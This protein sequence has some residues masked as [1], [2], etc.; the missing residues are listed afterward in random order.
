MK[1][2]IGTRKSRLALAQ[3]EMVVRALKSR[4]PDI[5]TEIVE[6]SSQG[7]RI[8]DRPI[9]EISGKGV[10]SSELEERILSGDI[11][12]A[13]HSAKDLDIDLPRG[14][15]ISAVLKRGDHRDVL[16]L[17]K[18]AEYAPTDKLL[19]G[20]GSIRRRENI[21]RFF[22]NAVFKDIRGNVETRLNK[23]RSGEYNGIILA[24]AGLERL[25][26]LCKANGNI[27]IEYSELSFKVFE[28]EEFV[29]AA[30]QGIISAEA[31][32]NSAAAEI[33]RDISDR[34]AY[35]SFETEREFLRICG[36]DCHTPAGIFTEVS[37]G[38]IRIICSADGREILAAEGNVSDKY[39]LLKGLTAKK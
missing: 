30:C 20:T 27:G 33:F 7:D 24:A 32:K 37:G 26:I 11:D 1:I 6:I 22:P 2:R 39:D 36:G 38:N 18:G 5:E 29:P 31:K 34:D 25:G 3:T 35:I 8:T 21:R 4:H 9:H 13:V 28:A 14:L 19:I 10:F 15:E 16:V 23:L 12:A 17:P